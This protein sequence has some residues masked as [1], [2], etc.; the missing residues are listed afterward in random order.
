MLKK[1]QLIL[2]SRGNSQESNAKTSRSSLKDREVIAGAVY[3]NLA[4]YSDPLKLWEL[5]T[6]LGQASQDFVN[7]FYAT[8]P[9]IKEKLRYITHNQIKQL[10]PIANSGNAAVY[11]SIKTGRKNTYLN[12]SPAAVEPKADS[13]PELT[14]AEALNLMK[15]HYQAYLHTRRSLSE[16]CIISKDRMSELNWYPSPTQSTTEQFEEYKTI[17][18]TP[19]RRRRETPEKE[20]YWA[21]K[22]CH[23][24]FVPKKMYCS[25]KL[26]R[27]RNLW[28]EKRLFKK[29]KVGFDIPWNV[30]LAQV[31]VIFDRRA[32]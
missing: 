20:Y 21:R 14:L 15:G 18:I 9:G 16:H 5:K 8:N 26:W 1:T 12:P 6:E 32:G 30:K 17:F 24:Q 27:E 19:E 13:I 31:S 22:W 25:T 10:K 29:Y 23:K 11:Y 3:I 7:S 28:G 4:D 2:A